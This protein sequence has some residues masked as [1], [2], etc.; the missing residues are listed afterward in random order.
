MRYHNIFKLVF[1]LIVLQSCSTPVADKLPWAF[2]ARA[3]EGYSISLESAEPKPGTPLVEGEEVQ[4][5][6][7]GRYAMTIAE[8]GGII[9]VPQDN[10]GAP[11]PAEGKQ[12]RM[13]I[14]GPQGKFT[15]TQTLKIPQGAKE[16]HIFVPI[17]PEG[18]TRTTGEITI[19]Y[20][21]VR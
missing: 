3:A 8:H 7:S 1:C 16:V 4:F 19:R 6:I 11:I 10:T 13:D 14:S 20:P 2:N 18:F 17:V 5:T 9:L 12:I 21:I 15:L